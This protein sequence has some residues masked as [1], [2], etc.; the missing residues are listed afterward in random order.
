VVAFGSVHSNSVNSGLLDGPGI[1]G[2]SVVE[3]GSSLDRRVWVK[4][5]F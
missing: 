3:F 5:G 1:G 2:N 4:G